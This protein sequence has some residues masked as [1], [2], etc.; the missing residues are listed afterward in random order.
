MTKNLFTSVTGASGWLLLSVLSSA[1]CGTGTGSIM[2]LSDVAGDTFQV[3]ALGAGGQITG[4]FSGSQ[5]HA[6][7]YNNGALTDLGDLGGGYSQGFAINAS[8][9]V[10]GGS[11]L[12]D[13]SFHAFLYSGQLLDLGTLEGTFSS[14]NSI[15]DNGWVVGSSSL[16]SGDTVAFLYTNGPLVNLGT[17]GG[18]YGSAMYVNNAG[19]ICGESAVASGD[20]HGFVYS[21]GSMLD[22][23]TLGGDYSS[24]AAVSLSGT[25]TGESSLANG[26]THAFSYSAGTITDLG[27]LGGSYS[28][29]SA[30]NNAGQILGS[31]TTVNEQQTHGFIWSDG[32]MIDLGNLG[33][34]YSSGF[35][36][37]NQGQ[38]VGESST[39]TGATH[40][41]VWQNGTMSDLN[42][43]LPPSSGWELF[44]AR[45]VNDSGRIV[46]YGLHSGSVQWFI[47]DLGS[48]NQPPIACAGPD[49]TV[50]CQAVTTLDG[51]CSSDPENDA[52][53][54]Q[55]FAL[56]SLLGTNATLTSSFPLGT[57]VIT[58]RVTDACGASA[59]ADVTVVVADTTPPSTSCP[60]PMTAASDSNC[61]SSIPDVLS[62]VVANDPCT[63]LGSLSVSQNPAAGTV[64]GLGP[65]T[66]TVTV[67]D[68]AGN[69][70]QCSVLFTV[71]DTM[72]PVIVGTPGP[73]ALSAGA[74]CQASVPNLAGSIQ[75]TDNCTPVNQLSIVQ[76]PSA[77]SQIGIGQHTITFTVSDASGN[78]STANVSLTVSDTTAPTILSVPGPITLSAAAHC[79]A[80]VPNLISSVQA[81]DNCTAVNQLV[82]T[83][84][85]PAGTLLPLGQY[86]VT[87][88]ATD[89]A[90]NSSSTG[91]SLTVTDLS[92][93]VIQ[94]V[95]ATPNVLSPPN[96]QLVPITVSVSVSDGC[97]S[98]PVSKIVSVTCS[99]TPAPGDIQI[100][101]DLTL[102]LAASKNTSGTSRL[103]TITVKSSDASGNSSFGTV[104]VTVPKSN[105]GSTSPSIN[106]KRLPVM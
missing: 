9:Q 17:L 59:Q 29:A 79:Q 106:G 70:S 44:S 98:A 67:T 55:W 41:F 2:S 49:Q 26:D 52:L 53:S 12:P 37:N 95:E 105:G 45:F 4:Y 77:G 42:T 18:T 76:S 85:P 80:S 88:S 83:Q 64:V 36:L 51:S 78:S 103:Y 63:P 100:T 8:G 23:G 1:A 86:V 34:G 11:L 66:I 82:I 35:A 43:L 3:S 24:S 16:A 72:P 13:F 101:G 60:G 102:M 50:E 90:G 56:G 73:I 93:P 87:I 68:G 84:N 97:D 89:L 15:N 104:T 65:H 10:A 99:E 57:N 54:F 21:A 58:L 92:A 46:G 20:V 40:A 96:H 28:S 14:P 6:F 7:L 69:S 19:F 71:V 75:A 48:S 94:T 30:I 47:M 91:V 33:G 25:A 81:A 22:V 39:S 31:S 5:T 38:V 27:T 32:S 62:Q 74:N 61:Q